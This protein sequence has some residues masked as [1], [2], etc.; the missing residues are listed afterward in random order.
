MPSLDLTII[1]DCDGVL[2]DSE[3]IYNSVEQKYLSQIGLNY[4][5]AEFQ[6]RF[7]GLTDVDYYNELK[8]DYQLLGKG[9]FPSEFAALVQAEC[10]ERFET[11]LVEINGINALL[12]Q[13]Q[14]TTAVASSSTVEAL[15][16]KL[17]I[18]K[19]H[20]RFHPHIYSGEQVERGKPSPDLFLFA[21]SQLGQKP[22]N[23]IVLED[24]VNGVRAGLAAGMTVWGFTGGGHADADLPNRLKQA[25][26][27]EVFSN[28][29]D[30]CSRI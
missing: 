11:E 8:R 26:A 1:F 21:A 28:Y 12:N 22:E 4:Q 7:V 19:L 23:C 6:T 13:F 17:R 24:S 10:W 20:A 18:T 5:N 9:E 25:G 15:H 30:I 3:K 2:I 14:G 27:H 29:P 16:K